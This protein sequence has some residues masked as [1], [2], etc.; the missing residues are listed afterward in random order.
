MAS[1]IGPMGPPETRY[2][3]AIYGRIRQHTA[4]EW[5]HRWAQ[6]AKG[7]HVRQLNA[8][9]SPKIRKLHDGR[10]K[11]H[12]AVLTQLRTGKIGFNEFLYKMRV[13]SALSPR[14]PCDLGA[15]TVRHILLACPEWKD[16]RDE[17]IRPLQTADLS[18]ILNSPKGCTAAI[19]FIIR[20]RLLEQF[21][22]IV[23]EL[24]ATPQRNINRETDSTIENRES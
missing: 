11:A 7:D 24:P 23:C 1:V 19:K 2:L 5:K 22:G 6:G 4:K 13:P 15:M 16:L 20:S 3:S 14:C 18:S 17:Y 8:E 10:E 9:P 12:S 21:K